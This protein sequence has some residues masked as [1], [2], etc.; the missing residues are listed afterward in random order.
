MVGILT[1]G[2]VFRV[3]VSITGVYQGGV[4]FAFELEDRGGSIKEVADVIRANGGCMTSILT[5]YDQ[6]PEGWRKVFFRVQSLDEDKLP[7]LV[8]EMKSKFKLL[9]MVNDK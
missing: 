5:S 2:D 1:Q 9:Y 3:L 8:E 6:V 4:Q 7:E